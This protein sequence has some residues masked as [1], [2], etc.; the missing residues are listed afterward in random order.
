MA[1]ASSV[2][3][4]MQLPYRLR[5]AAPRRLDGGVAA[6][7]A[8]GAHVGVRH[9]GVRTMLEHEVGPVHAGAQSDASRS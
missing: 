4:L 5:V 7:P 3:L 9:G 2:H 8:L 1:C 6:T